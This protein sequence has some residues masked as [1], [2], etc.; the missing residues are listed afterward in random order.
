MGLFARGDVGVVTGRGA[1]ERGR[2]A[3]LLVLGIG[4]P[5][6]VG[7]LCWGDVGGAE[8]GIGAGERGRGISLLAL[9]G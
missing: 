8:A 2:G 7:L 3:S 6:G 1:G 9:G 4:G 5:D